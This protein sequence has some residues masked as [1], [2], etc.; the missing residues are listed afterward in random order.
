ML[1]VTAFLLRSFGWKGA[2]V[3]V[4]IC[5]V[6]LISESADAIFEILKFTQSLGNNTDIEKPISAALKIL[7]CGYLFGICADICRE[8][9]E[10]GI[11]KAV[12]VTGRVEIIV[13]VLPFFKKIIDIGIG[14]VG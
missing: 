8:L 2:P 9:G 13:L 5:I 7:S 1:V 4:A 10:G 14:L 3:F 12:E 11:A 6:V